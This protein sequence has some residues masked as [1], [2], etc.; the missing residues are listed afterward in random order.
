MMSLSM[1]IVGRGFGPQSP[2]LKLNAR[3]GK[4]KSNFKSKSPTIMI[5]KGKEKR[6]KKSLQQLNFSV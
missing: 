1:F 6:K 3:G 4:I 5:K 2:S